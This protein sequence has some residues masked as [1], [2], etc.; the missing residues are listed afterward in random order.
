[1]PS[2]QERIELAFTLADALAAHA[3][4]DKLDKQGKPLVE[5]S[6]RVAATIKALPTSS[7]EQHIAALLHDVIEET[8]PTG[9]TPD[10]L[11]K[12]FGN[13]V[14]NLVDIL[15]R[16]P[17]HSRTYEQYIEIVA[18]YPHARAIKLAD[19]DDNLDPQRGPIDLSLKARYEKARQL[20]IDVEREERERG[21]SA[22][23]S[24]QTKGQ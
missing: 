15:T 4:S 9:L 5:H 6:R 21:Q 18:L 12:L 8:Y 14:A 17:Q 7:H 23:Q 16:W 13:S 19:L 2:D 3:L 24:T 1:M 11:A 22:S 10:A 20:L